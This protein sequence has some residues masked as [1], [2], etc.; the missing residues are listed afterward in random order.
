M[1]CSEMRQV[2]SSLCCLDGKVKRPV[3]FF[4][5]AKG[6]EYRGKGKGGIRVV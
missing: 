5:V 1:K 4:F 6:I 2:R 3:R